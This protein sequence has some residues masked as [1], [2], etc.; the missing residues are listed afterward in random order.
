MSL[1]GVKQ[2]R[3]ARDKRHGV[4]SLA[5]KVIA[6]PPNDVNGLAHIH[7]AAGGEQ[8]IDARLDRRRGSG[9]DRVS[10][11]QAIAGCWVKK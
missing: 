11:R 9:E 5:A 2:F 4:K 3:G 10:I 8:E 7:D 6:Q 1:C